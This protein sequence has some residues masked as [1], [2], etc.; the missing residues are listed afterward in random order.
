VYILFVKKNNPLE[1]RPCDKLN[2]TPPSKDQLSKN[3]IVNKHR[4]ICTTDEYAIRDFK[5][6]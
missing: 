4:P 5:S 2:Q 6:V 3:R 1:A